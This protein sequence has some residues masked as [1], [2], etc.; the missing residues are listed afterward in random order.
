MVLVSLE[1]F[2]RLL[3]WIICSFR[4][5]L[6]DGIGL[7]ESVGLKNCLDSNKVKYDTSTVFMIDS[8]FFEFH[9]RRLIFV[10]SAFWLGETD[11][12]L[13]NERIVS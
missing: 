12:S 1:R 4:V 9:A 7:M 3:D 6:L 5:D 13:P 2:G 8:P 11:Q 10:L